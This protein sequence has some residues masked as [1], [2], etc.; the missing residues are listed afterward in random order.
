METVIVY[1]YG[2]I[3][4]R[5][6]LT[7]QYTSAT[8]EHFFPNMFDLR[9][10]EPTDVG[11]ADTEGQLYFQIVWETCILLRSRCAVCEELAKYIKN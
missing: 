4:N 2:I 10:V 6:S 7:T 11:P 3:Q 9:W 5:H 1:F 8:T